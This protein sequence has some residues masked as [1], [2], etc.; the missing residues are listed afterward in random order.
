LTIIGE[1]PQDLFGVKVGN[2]GS[3]GDSYVKILPR[4]PRALFTRA[5]TPGF[6]TV[7]TLDSEIGQRVD[8]LSGD[9]KDT[10]PM[11]TVTAIRPTSR[12]VFLSAKANATVSTT[13]RFHPNSCFINK[14]HQSVQ[15]RLPH[16]HK[17]GP[18]VGP[19]LS[20]TLSR[21]SGMILTYFLLL[22]PFVSNTTLPVAFAKIV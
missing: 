7:S 10:A 8:A 18:L 20:H 13:A 21:Y 19:F 3:L 14:F 16:G 11:A 9:K 17:K 6:G 2:N 5:S 15:E 12:D 22:G 4:R 1:I